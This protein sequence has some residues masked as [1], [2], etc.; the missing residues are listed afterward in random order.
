MAEIIGE[1]GG[2]TGGGSMTQSHSYGVPYEIWESWSTFTQD[3]Y[4][5]DYYRTPEQATYYESSP[6]AAAFF[7]VSWMDDNV[8]EPTKKVYEDVT[9]IG[10]NALSWIPILALVYVATR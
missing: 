10:S 8:V 2:V 1:Y 5:Q 9:D 3:K 6:E 4:L 7:Y